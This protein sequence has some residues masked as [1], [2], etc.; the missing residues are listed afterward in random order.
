MVKGRLGFLRRVFPS[1]GGV[2]VLP[3]VPQERTVPETSLT[4]TL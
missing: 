2:A 3:V 1:E 4:I